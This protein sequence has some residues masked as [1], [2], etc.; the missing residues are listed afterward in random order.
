MKKQLQAALILSML[1]LSAN[2]FGQA[3]GTKTYLDI[4]LNV[5]STNLNYGELN[6]S[7]KEY[8]K[9]VLGAQVGVSF[10]AGIT[11][12]F[13]FVSELYFIMKGGTL[14]ADNPL[15]YNKTTLRLYTIE[16]PVL[17][18]F[19]FGKIYVNA[20]PYIAYNVYGTRKMEGSTKAL[21][22]DDSNDAFKRWDAGIQM[23]A[24]Y[25]FKVKQK[26][27]VV[28]MRYTYGLSN[29]SNNQEMYNR[30][31]NI[32]LHCSAPWKKYPLGKK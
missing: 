23:G 10:Q 21:P 7:L 14:K 4:L 28:D 3:A 2:T 24:G 26:A 19:N 5:V 13:S 29:I 11:P 6:S 17:V 27:V 32:S 22:F 31:L 30:Y 18:R 1:F 15:T 16:L 9:P 8:K 12:K 20:G 25:R